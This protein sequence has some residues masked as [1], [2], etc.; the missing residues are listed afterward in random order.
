M[1][2]VRQAFG[3]AGR[4]GVAFAV[5]RLPCQRQLFASYFHGHTRSYATSKPPPR[6]SQQPN[7][8][9]EESN[10]RHSAQDGNVALNIPFNAAGGSGGPVNAGLGGGGIFKFTKSP[11]FDAALTTIVGL[12]MGTCLSV[13][14]FGTDNP[15]SICW[16]HSLHRVV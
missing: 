15:G 2:L 8:E 16:W 4:R 9:E 7:T 1:N 13:T 6:E 12:G 10:Y 11:M 3:S 14:S 5:C